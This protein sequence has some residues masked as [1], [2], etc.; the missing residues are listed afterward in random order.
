MELIICSNNEFDKS[1][2]DYYA[3][4]FKQ[5]EYSLV[6]VYREL[7]TAQACLVTS[8]SSSQRESHLLEDIRLSTNR[9]PVI[10]DS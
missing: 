10:G 9:C 6:A 4:H 7:L 1:I 3:I 5:G 2:L 8:D